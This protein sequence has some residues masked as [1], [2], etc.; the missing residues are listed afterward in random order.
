MHRT[1]LVEGH[2]RPVRAPLR[3]PLHGGALRSRLDRR[4][5]LPSAVLPPTDTAPDR[6][7][8]PLA[9]SEPRVRCQS[10]RIRRGE[11]GVLSSA[12]VP[13]VPGPADPALAVA[14]KEVRVRVRDDDVL[15]VCAGAGIAACMHDQRRRGDGAAARARKAEG[16]GAVPRVPGHDRA[17]FWLQSHEVSLRGTGVVESSNRRSTDHDIVFTRSSSAIC[18]NRVGGC[19]AANDYDLL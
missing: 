19:A 9:G 13:S 6:T 2:P 18:A 7:Q 16:L 12:D 3:P 5:A 17:E 14:Q 15:A 11:A 4:V 1:H 8:A 10:A